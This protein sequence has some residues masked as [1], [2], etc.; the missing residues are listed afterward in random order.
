MRIDQP[1][2]AKKPQHPKDSGAAVF[3]CMQEKTGRSA[4][5][6]VRTAH[7]GAQME[8]NANAGGTKMDAVVL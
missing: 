7:P 1:T 6:T 2:L 8:F 5:K 3:C 4:V